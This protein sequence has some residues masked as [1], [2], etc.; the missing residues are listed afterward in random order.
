LGGGVVRDDRL[1]RWWLWG[2]IVLAAIPTVVPVV[3]YA[4]ALVSL[5]RGAWFDG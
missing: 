1:V 5:V 4:V 3:M 2:E